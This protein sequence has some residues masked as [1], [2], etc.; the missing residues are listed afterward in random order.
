MVGDGERLKADASGRSIARA[1][2]MTM[3]VDAL[4]AVG[5]SAETNPLA[6]ASLIVGVVVDSGDAGVW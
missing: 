1:W 4:S 3:D 6:P 2:T 5:A